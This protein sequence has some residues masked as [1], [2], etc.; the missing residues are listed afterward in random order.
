MST[1]STLALVAAPFL[2]VLGLLFGLILLAGGGSTGLP[3]ACQQAG[4]SAAGQPPLTQYYIDAAHW[5]K[6]GADGYAYLAA[7]N[8]V[9]TA[10]GTNVAVSPAGAVGWMQFEP[11]TY[12]EYSQTAGATPDAPANPDDPQDAIYTAAA[13]LHANGAPGNW[14]TAIFAYNHAGWYVSEVEA[15]AE[16]YIGING[17]TQ[18]RDRSSRL[19][20]DPAHSRKRPPTAADDR[21]RELPALPQLPGGGA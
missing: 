7:I 15:D 2:I 8:K 1:N 4:P 10:F 3:A 16:R 13:M 17:L 5:F 6:L 11:A 21:G 20:G 9:E 18:P 12:A 14:P 19:R